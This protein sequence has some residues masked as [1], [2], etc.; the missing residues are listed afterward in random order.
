VNAEFV[1]FLTVGSS[2]RTMNKN[3]SQCGVT[4]YNNLAGNTSMSANSLWMIRGIVVSATVVYLQF[5]NVT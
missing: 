4:S 2:S 1:I 3:L 5:L